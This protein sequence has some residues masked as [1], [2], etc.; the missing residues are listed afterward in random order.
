MASRYE[1]A[2]RRQV[3]GCGFSDRSREIAEPVGKLLD[4]GQFPGAMDLRMR[5]ENLLDQTGPGAGHA[6]HEDRPGRARL[7]LPQTLQQRRRE[8]RGDVC[9]PSA[10]G[11][12]IISELGPFHAV[13]LVEM[14]E[15]TVGLAELEKNLAQREMQQNLVGLHCRAGREQSLHG[16][17]PGIVRGA[18]HEVG[19]VE[20]GRGRARE[21]SH[22][23][24]ERGFG[25]CCLTELHEQ[26]GPVDQG[27]FRGGAGQS[28][29]AV[30]GGKGFVETPQCAQDIAQIDMGQGKIRV[31]A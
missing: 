7:A 20:P 25:L 11:I 22:G 18:A 28:S 23:L 16:G 8:V 27:L 5:G 21:G 26:N 1:I 2:E 31:A 17:N 30:I 3:R 14:G 15:G 10:G 4:M 24:R 29:G 9:H 6:D 12:R 19:A 13:A